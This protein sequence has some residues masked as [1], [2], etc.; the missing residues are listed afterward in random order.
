MLSEKRTLER[1]T[2]SWSNS[3]RNPQHTEFLESFSDT[4]SSEETKI[5]QPMRMV[6]LY[7]STLREVTVLQ[8]R[9]KFR[10][11]RKAFLFLK[12]MELS[13][14]VGGYDVAELRRAA[15]DQD[16]FE[17]MDLKAVQRFWLWPK[18]WF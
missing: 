8:A 12:G 16:W 17:H 13:L 3:N 11:Y 9:R 2:S 7:Q 18:W 1:L 5:I 6:E 14:I 15:F 10:R 4:H